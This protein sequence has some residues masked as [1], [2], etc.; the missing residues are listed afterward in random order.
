MEQVV[1]RVAAQ[2]EFG[3]DGCRRSALVGAPRELERALQIRGR[4]SDFRPRQAD[5]DAREPVFVQ[6]VETARSAT[7]TRSGHAG[8]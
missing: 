3:E 4:I 5:G 6:V 2:V 7:S 8:L 1:Q